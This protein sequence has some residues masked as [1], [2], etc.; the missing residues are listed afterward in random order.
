MLRPRNGGEGVVFI[1]QVIGLVWA[2]RFVRAGPPAAVPL[3]ASSFLSNCSYYSW[4]RPGMQDGTGV[5][6]PSWLTARLMAERMPLE[7][8]QVDVMAHAYA[9]PVPAVLVLEVDVGHSLGVRALLDGVLLVVDEGEAVHLLAVDSVEEG[10]NGA[11][12]GA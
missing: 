9:E 10:V 11:V 3:S 2:A 6:L 1:H 12:A 7:G 4:F 8:G 5:H